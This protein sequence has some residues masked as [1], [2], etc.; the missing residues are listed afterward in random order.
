MGLD[1]GFIHKR[2]KGETEDYTF[3][4]ANH[5]HNYFIENFHGG[6]DDQKDFK[7]PV[8]GIKDFRDILIQVITSM[9]SSETTNND[10]LK[11]YNSEVAEDLLPT[12]S[13]F[14]FGSTDYDEYY[15]KDCKKALEMCNK[16]LAEKPVGTITYW[17][18]W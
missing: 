7:I 4:K 9:E 3:R 13:G 5:I 14:F 10:G 8:K 2:P 11:V 18:W 6:I 15:L 12:Q 1:H 17:C 16:I